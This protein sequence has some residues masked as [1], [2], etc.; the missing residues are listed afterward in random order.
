MIVIL[1][2]IAFMSGAVL[3][4]LAVD[5]GINMLINRLTSRHFLIW[6]TDGVGEGSIS[7][8][9]KGGKYVNLDAAIIFI[10]DNDPEAGNSII[11][12][13]IIELDKRDLNE[14]SEEFTDPEPGVKETKESHVNSITDDELIHMQMS[15]KN[16]P[17]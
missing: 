11:I 2:L 13:N 14:W 8:S 6:Y 3:I 7:L 5:G 17:N 9:I 4:A 16:K 15:K 10:K 12:T 1:E